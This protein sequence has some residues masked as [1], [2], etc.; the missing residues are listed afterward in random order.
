M[1]VIGTAS[2]AVQVASELAQGA[3][4]FSV[5]QR[6]AAYVP[7]NTNLDYAM[8]VKKLFAGFPWLITVKQ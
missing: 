8:W 1:A 6:T 2:S 3:A 4:K 5:F 7:V